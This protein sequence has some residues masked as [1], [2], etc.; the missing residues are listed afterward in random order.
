M[1][2]I[3][4]S[5][6]VTIL[7]IFFM[8]FFLKKEKTRAYQIRLEQAEKE[9]SILFEQ[10]L[11]LLTELHQLF[12]EKETDGNFDYLCEL[13][14]DNSGL[15]LN[16]ILNRAY[17]ELKRFLDSKRG[18]IPED[19]IKI[20]LEDLYQCDT[21]CMA[22]KEYY[23]IQADNI[24][25]LIKKFPTNLISKFIGASKIEKYIDLIEEEFEILKEK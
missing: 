25:K 17:S 15:T 9:L 16:F 24:N 6:T 12:S 5:I 18:Y 3:V 14:Q 8:Y 7:A 23:N 19:E 1:I 13:E 21:E 20:K 10:K 4:V 22:I 2:L 11:T